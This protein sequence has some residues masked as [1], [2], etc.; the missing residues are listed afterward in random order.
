MGKKEALPSQ[1]TFLPGPEGFRPSPFDGIREVVANYRLWQ[2]KPEG[3]IRLVGFDGRGVKT[4]DRS[5]DPDF[6]LPSRPGK[7]EKKDGFAGLVI[8]SDGPVD[9]N[10]VGVYSESVCRTRGLMVVVEKGVSGLSEEEKDQRAGILKKQG[11][12]Q[13]VI[14]ERRVGEER[15]VVW[16]ARR[17]K[18][19]RR[20]AV[21]I[22]ET[23]A[24]FTVR[25]GAGRTEKELAQQ[26]I[27]TVSSEEAKRLLRKAS[28]LPRD[29]RRVADG[30][31]REFTV[32]GCGCR[33][34]QGTDGSWTV[35]PCNT[36]SCTLNQ[37]GYFKE[38]VDPLR[39]FSFQE[40]RERDHFIDRWVREAQIGQVTTRRRRGRNCRYLV[41]WAE[42]PRLDP[43]GRP[44]GW[45]EG[46]VAVKIK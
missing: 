33:L 2:E 41:V 10:R 14:S 31:G 46:K 37:E 40:V 8:V 16:R 11:F 27:V 36:G 24:M 35:E 6:W 3:R 22:T 7:R 13:P 39:T 29:A 4:T 18:P 45:K 43:K 17:P 1:R 21:D 28:Y 12:N 9:P 38:G 23:R 26:G 19:R 25:E 15:I 32:S 34:R 42:L 5:V 20:A 44:V 30:G